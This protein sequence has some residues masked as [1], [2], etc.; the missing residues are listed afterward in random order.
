MILEART[1]KCYHFNACR[2]G[3]LGNRATDSNRG[4]RIT[5]TFQIR[6]DISCQCLGTGNN[7]CA[8]G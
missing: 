2:L 7:M 3:A 6:T 4:L 8:I 1:V 5:G